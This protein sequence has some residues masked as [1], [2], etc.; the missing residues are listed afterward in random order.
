MK[1]CAGLLFPG[2]VAIGFVAAMAVNAAG[3][4]G[5]VTLESRPRFA[6]CAQVRMI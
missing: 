6:D 1:K 3:Q 5:G 2:P 4:S